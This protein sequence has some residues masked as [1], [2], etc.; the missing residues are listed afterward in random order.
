MIFL[1]ELESLWMKHAPFISAIVSSNASAQRF[2]WIRSAGQSKARHK[3]KYDLNAI[4]SDL[5]YARIIA[6]CSKLGSYEYCTRHCWSLLNTAC[7]ICTALFLSLPK[8]SISSRP[9]FIRIPTMSTR[10]TNGSCIT[11]VRIIIWGL[12]KKAE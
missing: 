2:A 10:G 11:T 12:K 5:V 4:L 9:S 8:K 7:M 1:R 3:F 6:P